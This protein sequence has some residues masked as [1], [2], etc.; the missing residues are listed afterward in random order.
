MPQELMIPNASRHNVATFDVLLRE[1]G[2]SRETPLNSNFEVLS[3]AITK[4]ANRLSTATIVLRDGEAAAQS[5]AAS[6]APDLVP[7]K[8]ITIK[9]G[10]DR[11]NQPLF[12]G[13]I[14]RHGI[15]VRE[16]GQPEL[17]VECRDEAV[18]MTIG[19]HS[20]YFGDMKDS[21]VMEELVGNYQGLQTD[22]ERTRVTHKEL[23]Q[24]HCTDWD[25][26]LL[27]AEANGKLVLTNDGVVEIKKP[28]T[29]SSP[30]L[31]LVY[32]AS[33]FEFESEM[34]VR[35]QWASVQARAWD[36]GGQDLFQSEASAAAFAEPGNIA[37]S[38]LAQ[39]MQLP[40]Y[41]LQHSGYLPQEELQ[42]WAEATL[43]KS[44]LSKIKGRARF[45]GFAGVKPGDTVQLDGVGERFNGKAFVT[46]VRHE[47]GKGIWDTHVQ[48]GLDASWL[49]ATADVMDRPSA[50]LLP[51]V[52][53]L[54]IGKV[55]QL[56]DD[57]D[58]EDRILV[59]MPVIDNNARGI[60][61]RMATLDAGNDRGS[62]FRPELDDEV[63]VGF[64]N[65]DP[66]DAVVL[67]MLHS[68]AK[69]APIQAQDA[70]HE[71]GI[72]TRSHLRLHF[73]DDTKTITIDTPA[74]NSIVLDEQGSSITIKDQNSNKLTLEPG[75]MQ[76]ESPNSISIKAGLNLTLSAG[77]TLAIGGGECFSGCRWHCANDRGRGKALSTGH[78]GD[79][80]VIGED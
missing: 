44:R 25:F 72:I 13:V 17:V 64:V 59:K 10:R 5:F 20:R 7:G 26:L 42:Q 28:D 58:G 34:D 61:A 56:Q 52:H 55:V 21:E 16:N 11:N 53:G 57:P 35:Q 47:L 67:G 6:N 73:N 45:Q 51:S 27:R 77:A 75:G 65:A 80:W 60:W 63:I 41:E 22:V 32:G 33:L 40:H 19:R 30:V 1:P 54:Q 14:I 43:M 78:C 12:K 36:Y 4:T 46:G 23:V 38:E 15:K 79:Q 24:H 74:G 29:D 3:I 69:P 76:L 71:K 9:V 48:F 2:S 18:R 66:R 31:Q 50:G 68:S 8:R 39:V 62:F 70:N 49:S 37:G